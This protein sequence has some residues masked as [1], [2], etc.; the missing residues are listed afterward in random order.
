MLWLSQMVLISGSG[1]PFRW[2]HTP[3]EGLVWGPA[4]PRSSGSLFG[5]S[6]DKQPS[7]QAASFDQSVLATRL[8]NALQVD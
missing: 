7:R 1:G 6:S 3:L 5:E 8:A 4:I 2:V